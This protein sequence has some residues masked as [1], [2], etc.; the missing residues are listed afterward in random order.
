MPV[1]T[2]C[3]AANT[4]CHY[5]RSKR[6]RRKSTKNDSAQPLDADISLLTA[7]DFVGWLDTALPAELDL[8]V[9]NNTRYP[10]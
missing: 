7:D 5:I 1:C 3:Q 10:Y 4:E 8:D 9:R 2:R 6:G